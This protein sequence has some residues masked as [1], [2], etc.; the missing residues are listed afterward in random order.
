MSTNFD[1]A[2]NRSKFDSKVEVY[3]DRI[4]LGVSCLFLGSPVTNAVRVRVV[5]PIKHI[6]RKFKIMCNN[7]IVVVMAKCMSHIRE[8]KKNLS[9]KNKKTI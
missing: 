5:R 6:L 8:N 4:M 7:R 2:C 3:A 1:I 9:R